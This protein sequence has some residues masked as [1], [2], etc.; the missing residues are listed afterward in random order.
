MDGSKNLCLAIL[1]GPPLCGASNLNNPIMTW[2]CFVCLMLI[3]FCNVAVWQFDMGICSTTMGFGIIY[4]KTVKY[5][6]NSQVCIYLIIWCFEPSFYHFGVDDP[7]FKGKFFSEGR[8]AIFCKH[9]TV[10]MYWKMFRSS[11][12]F[13]KHGDPTSNTI[14]SEKNVPLHML[15]KSC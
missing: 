14:S 8:I 11:K 13:A 7:L 6:L 10:P 4:V 15:P 5:R 12:M 2:G 9:I 3:L 1:L